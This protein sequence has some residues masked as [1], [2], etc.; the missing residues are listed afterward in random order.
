MLGSRLGGWWVQKKPPS[1]LEGTYGPHFS[2]RHH[3][4]VTLADLAVQVS[5]SPWAGA[6]S[7][8]TQFG[9][10]GGREGDLF[11]ESLR[12]LIIYIEQNAKY[13]PYCHTWLFT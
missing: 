3:H 6:K 7:T 5:S 11:L 8:L 9:W 1:S 13:M 12:K 10:G 2:L 4:L